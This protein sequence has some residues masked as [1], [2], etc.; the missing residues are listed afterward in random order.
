MTHYIDAGGPFAAAAVALLATGFA[1]RWQ[2]SASTNGTAG[3]GKKNKTKYT[4][5][6]CGQNAWAKPEARLICGDC[7]QPMIAKE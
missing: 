5:E 3:R 4:C 1:L 2:A 6:T 7:E